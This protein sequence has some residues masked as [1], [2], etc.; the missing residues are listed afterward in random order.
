L[1]GSW[2]ADTGFFAS[3]NNATEPIVE[4]A[5]AGPVFIVGCLSVIAW[6]EHQ[7]SAIPID[8]ALI[9]GLEFINEGTVSFSW[10]EP[11]VGIVDGTA[12]FG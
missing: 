8:C 7:S 3:S 2:V 5:G 12:P 9:A 4:E 11:F 6:D 10:P 1:Y